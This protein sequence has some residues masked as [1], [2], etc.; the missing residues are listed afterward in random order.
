VHPA[1]VGERVVVVP[2][3]EDAGTRR[4]Q[5]RSGLDAVRAASRRAVSSETITSASKPA[6]PAPARTR[7]RPSA[8]ALGNSRLTRRI[9]ASETTA[10]DGGREAAAATPSPRR[11]ERLPAEA[12]PRRHLDR[13][14]TGDRGEV[15]KLG[16]EKP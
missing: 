7:A 11:G 1:G 5:L 8:V 3:G 6:A 12:A 15:G 10:S 16:M 9:V 2:I 13:I 4:A 14:S